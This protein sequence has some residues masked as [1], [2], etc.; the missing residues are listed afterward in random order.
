[1]K[2]LRYI[3]AVVAALMAVEAS[4]WT[5]TQNR[6]ILMLAEENLSSRAKR[7][8][9]EILGTPL[10]EVKFANKGKSQTRLN[11]SG[12][13]VTT[14]EKDAVV[15]LERAIATLQRK[16]ATAEER[17]AALLTAVEMT[18]DIHC[19][20]NVLID[21]HLERDFVY[22]RDNGRPKHSRWFKL[23]ER[24]W[25]AMWHSQYHKNHGAFSAEMYLYDWHIATKGMAKGYKREAIAPRV[26]AERTGERVFLAL[27]TFQPDAV[28]NMLEITKH[29]YL[30]D[31]SM[32]DAAFHLANLLNKTLK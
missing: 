6:A 18:V 5:C 21:K 31:E 24:K 9:S 17:K 22:Q 14:D 30:N 10:S 11:E 20:A 26:W 29:E 3:V 19:P 16:D 25:Q 32:Y 23:S 4:A 15:K 28:I 1:M 27:K 12:K 2:G 8:L 7:E 13:S